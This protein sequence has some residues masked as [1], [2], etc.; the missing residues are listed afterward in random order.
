M[1][2]QSEALASFAAFTGADTAVGQ[3]MLEA[4]GWD[5]ESAVQL[6]FAT[7][8]DAP[9]ASAPLPPPAAT[10]D[11]A[12]L[13]R[14]LAASVGAPMPASAAGRH[15]DASSPTPGGMGMGPGAGPSVDADAALAAALAQEQFQSAAPSGGQSMDVDDG[16]RQAMRTGEEDQLYQQL[17]TERERKRQRERDLREVTDA[18]GSDGKAVGKRNDGL[19]KLFAPPDYAYTHSL[20][21]ACAEGEKQ[22]KWIILNLISGTDFLSQTLNRDVWGNDGVRLPVTGHFILWQ[23]YLDQGEGGRAQECYKVDAVPFVGM[24]D[25]R[26][27]QCVERMDLEKWKGKDGGWNADKIAEHLWQWSAK[28]ES[29][30]CPAGAHPPASAA[31]SAPAAAPAGP[32][33]A[34]SPM[35]MDEDAELQRAVAMSLSDQQPPQPAAPAPAAPEPPAPE[36]QPRHDL[37]RLIAGPEQRTP[38]H[39]VRVRVRCTDGRVADLSMLP[40][41]PLAALYDAVKRDMPE[42]RTR[43]FNL[44][45][46]YPPKPVPDSGTDSVE[47]QKLNN[48][49]LTMRWI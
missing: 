41:T 8:G 3:Q 17:A 1:A 12:D 48:E 24:L 49:M 7:Q 30:L 18:F 46:S 26:T 21:E 36:W 42:A 5:V 28:H 47:Q 9:Q 37:G 14:A 39:S 35:P 32:P 19:E 10:A 16:V 25:P 23:R 6:Y 33:A 15:A 31:P 44:M 11:D 45:F 38:E 4:S 40:D 22:G 27:R 34:P 29:E 13:A 43:G 20:E 2:Q